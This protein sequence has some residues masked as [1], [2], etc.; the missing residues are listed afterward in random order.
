MAAMATSLSLSGEVV[1]RNG[2]PADLIE[3]ARGLEKIFN[4]CFG[5]IYK[6]KGTIFKRTRLDLTKELDVLRNTL[7]KEDK[8]RKAEKKDENK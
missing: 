2:Q 8:K 6:K 5:G 3:L 4:F 1:H 7:I